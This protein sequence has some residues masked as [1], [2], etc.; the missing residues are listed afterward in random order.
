M[1]ILAADATYRFAP[2]ITY[3]IEASRVIASGGGFSGAHSDIVHDEVAHIFWQAALSNL[4]SQ[5]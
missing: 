1:E 2:G 3:N 4:P 5:G